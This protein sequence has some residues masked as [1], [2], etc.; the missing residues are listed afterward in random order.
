MPNK[1]YFCAQVHAK[2]SPPPPYMHSIQN[3]NQ[4]CM[5]CGTAPRQERSPLSCI[6]SLRHTQANQAAVN[7]QSFV[8]CQYVS[9]TSSSEAAAYLVVGA[10]REP[11]TVAV[12]WCDCWPSANTLSR[13]LT[14]VRN[15]TIAVT[16]SLLPRVSASMTSLLAH[17]SGCL[18]VSST[19][20]TA[21]SSCIT[22]HSPSLPKIKKWSASLST[23]CCTSGS[24]VTP[25]CFSS[26]SPMHR[27]TCRPD[28]P[29]RQLLCWKLTCPPAATTRS[30]SLDEEAV[31]SLLSASAA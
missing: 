21:C 13:V 26:K 11:C 10:L 12:M 8:I 16:L 28:E 24:D 17:M 2:C 19:R 15:A 4:S 31:W 7:H 29:M 23:T 27:V 25:C 18:T 6:T 30:R 5:T 1:K 22:S 9:R 3:H 20:P 14:G